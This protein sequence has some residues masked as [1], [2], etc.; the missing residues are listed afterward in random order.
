MLGDI[1]D[2]HDTQN[3]AIERMRTDVTEWIR[4]LESRITKQKTTISNQRMELTAQSRDQRALKMLM[5]QRFEDMK[6][7]NKEMM[8]AIKASTRALKESQETSKTLNGQVQGLL[9][10][11][12]VGSRL[13]GRVKAEPRDY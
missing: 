6:R 10:G 13:S 9:K 4:D 5:D 11:A 12:Q 2:T 3:K 1:F 8:D 7:E